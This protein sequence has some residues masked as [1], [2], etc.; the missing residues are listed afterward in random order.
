MN[1][2][3]TTE[4]TE[5]QRAR[6][7]QL[8]LLATFLLNVGV[9]VA[10]LVY[11]WR[12]DALSIRADGLHSVADSL[13]NVVALIAI[14]FASQ[15]ADDDHPYGHRKFEFV[16][17]GLIGVS[18]LLVAFDIGRDAFERLTGDATVPRLDNW[19][20]VVL[21]G[22]AMVNVLVASWE[23][24]AAKRLSSPLLGSD[25]HHTRSDLFVTL[26]VLGAVFATRMG[27]PAAD[28]AIAGVVAAIV[29]WAGVRVLRENASYLTDAAALDPQQVLDIVTSVDGVLH[30]HRVRSRGGPGHLFVDLHVHVEPE[31]T[32]KRSHD[33][34]HEVM[35]AVKAG[36]EGVAEV[37]VHIEPEDHEACE[38]A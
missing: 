33:L 38:V 34:T 30:A 13:N 20:Y 16:A 4:L 12:A 35:D 21:I 25:A 2:E 14:W 24:R 6:A 17:A 31:M 26:G 9:A 11:G 8:V 3:A 27:Y 18:L 5:H 19:A 22:T 37:N 10:K 36:I 1:A 23:A 32:V 7:V 28:L 15:P 29:A